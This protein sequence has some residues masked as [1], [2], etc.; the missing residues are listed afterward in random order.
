MLKRQLKKLN[1]DRH[2]FSTPANLSSCFQQHTVQGVSIS[3]SS[4]NPVNIPWFSEALPSILTLFS[5]TGFTPRKKY[6]K[7]SISEHGNNL[8][9]IGLY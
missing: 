1:I 8:R 3:A 7:A 4:R 6:S 2:H 5:Q 9:P